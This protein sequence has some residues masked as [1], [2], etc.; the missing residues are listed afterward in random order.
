VEAVRS[1]HRYAVVLPFVVLAVVLLAGGALNSID[2]HARVVDDLTDKPVKDTRI[3][4]G[5]RS[6]VTD[7][8]GEFTFPAVPRTSKFAVEAQGYLR[9][10]VATTV[11][12]IRLK[13]LSVTLYTYDETKTPDD[14]VKNPQ[15]RDPKDPTKTLAVGNES[16]QIVVAPHPG[17]DAKVLV[18]GAG[19][20]PKT[21]TIEGVLMQI[22]LTPGGTG[23]PPLPSP[24]PAPGATPSPSAPAPSP[25][26]SPTSS[27]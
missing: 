6:T 9:Q 14:R 13:P 21:V 17:K 19:F 1:R 26:P 16:G 5:V 11:E 2:A 10:P 4:H 20:A 12:E 15:A 7:A 3:T 25:A 27:P 24:S 22:G 8:N 18:C 23:C